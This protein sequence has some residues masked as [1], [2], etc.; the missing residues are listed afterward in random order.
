M[1]VGYWCQK[2]IN[3]DWK[4]KQFLDKS[5]KA[6]TFF[7]HMVYSGN[8]DITRRNCLDTRASAAMSDNSRNWIMCMTICFGRRGK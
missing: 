7:L 4:I 8:D 1:D 3:T 2:T 6:G 5:L